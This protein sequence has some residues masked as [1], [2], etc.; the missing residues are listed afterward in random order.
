MTLSLTV[1]PPAP[2][3]AV[4]P[5]GVSF[6]R[7]LIDVTFVLEKRTFAE[8]GT[9][10]V[11]LS[12]LRISSRI[13][14]AGG[15]AFSSAHLQI[16]GLTLSMMNDLSTLGSVPMAFDKNRM[17]VEA[18]DAVSGMS[19]VFVGEIVQA[20]GDFDGMPSVPFH[21]R[22]NVGR[23]ASLAP[24]APLSLRGPVDAAGALSGLATQMGWAFENNGVATQLPSSYWPGTAREQAAAIVRDAGIEWNGGDNGTLA[25]WPRGGSRGGLIPL[26]ASPPDGGMI[27]YPSYT[28]AGIVLR[29]VF[30][31][32]LLGVGGKIQVRSSLTPAAGTW[33]VQNLSYDLDANVP[34]GKWEC[35]VVATLPGLVRVS[36]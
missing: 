13:V 25:I 24:V 31:A 2:P 6:V 1:G 9:N 34:G 26:I 23:N 10:T 3:V 4:A 5:S 17:I 36:P 29:T 27:G 30:V 11:K 35:S 15:R 21:V 22:A 16:Y 18:G 20:Y 12:G 19:T 33:A 28:N 7:R 32:G 8:S 14:K